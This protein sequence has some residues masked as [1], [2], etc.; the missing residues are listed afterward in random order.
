[1]QT[2]PLYITKL[3]EDVV[4]GNEQTCYVKMTWYTRDFVDPL[5]F[6]NTGEEIA[7]PKEA[8]KGIVN[9]IR[10]TFKEILE[11]DED[12]YYLLLALLNGSADN[13]SPNEAEGQLV[14]EVAE[15]QKDL[16]DSISTKTG[17][18]QRKRKKTS[19]NV[20]LFY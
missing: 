8:I 9:N 2:S 18:P 6:K 11:I 10:V 15:K 14:E 1:M 20:F 13:T 5:L 16:D 4:D 12:E 3:L 7:I 19:K 17:R